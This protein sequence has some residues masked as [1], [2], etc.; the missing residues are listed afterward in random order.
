MVRLGWR[1]IVGKGALAHH[2]AED[3]GFE[4]P[5]AYARQVPPYDKQG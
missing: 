3:G 4:H 1:R 5:I 2:A